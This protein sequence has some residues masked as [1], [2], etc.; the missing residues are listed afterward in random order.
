M[1]GV[2]AKEKI[3]KAIREKRKLLTNE[4]NQTKPDFSKAMM[5]RKRQWNN[6]LK[7]LKENNYL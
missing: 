3:S 7:T 4:N 2:E 5:E 6:I 1:Q